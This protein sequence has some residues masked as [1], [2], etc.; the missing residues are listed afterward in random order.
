[1]TDAESSPAGFTDVDKTK[2]TQHFVDFLDRV[3]SEK[4]IKEG[5]ETSFSLLEV[6]PGDAVLDVGCGTGDDVIS[7]AKIVGGNG[8]AVGIDSSEAMILEARKRG[9]ESKVLN[10]EFLVGSVYHIDFPNQT[11]NGVLADRVFQHLEDPRKALSEMVRVAKKG[12]GRIVTHD[13]DWD[14]F[15]IDSEFPDVTRK[16]VRT[17]S[18]LLKNGRAGSR[19]Y[20]MFKEA[21][22]VDVTV[23]TGSAVF[24][25][26]D[27]G[28]K[29]LQLE[30]ASTDAVEKGM[31]SD[32]ELTKWIADL[33]RR[34]EQE[35]FFASFMTFR[36]AG[37][38]P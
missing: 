9:T 34:G 5:K 28:F 22:L 20:G 4:G 23:S 30:R 17:R 2:D 36:V 25:D 7:L 16:I 14:T 31:I 10:A 35:R 21:G 19:M 15:V 18:G 24:T 32:K 11:F 8:R 33:Q 3:R 38:K 1:M 12:D 6:N 26:Y 27:Y 29:H 13:P 37:T